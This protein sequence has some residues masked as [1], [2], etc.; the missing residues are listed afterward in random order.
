VLYARDGGIAALLFQASVCLDRRPESSRALSSLVEGGEG[1]GKRFAV[2]VLHLR[3][4]DSEASRNR[5]GVAPHIAPRNA[6]P[7]AK[8][9]ND[10]IQGSVDKDAA[11][12]AGEGARRKPRPLR[13]GVMA[14]AAPYVDVH[15]GMF[16]TS[17][18]FVGVLVPCS[19][20]AAIC[21]FLQ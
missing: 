11:P 8:G 5:T 1:E 7:Q 20:C 14:V 21:N 17:V 15:R 3:V 2:G 18:A 9:P 12:R 6:T 10:L 13:T 19:A 16:N 4:N